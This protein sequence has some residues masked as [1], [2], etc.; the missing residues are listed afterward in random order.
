MSEIG[1]PDGIYYEVIA[2]REESR[3]DASR[4]GFN[5]LSLPNIGIYQIETRGYKEYRNGE[6]VRSWQD[7]VENFVRCMDV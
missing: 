5:D 7:D 4:C 6:L 2:T 3:S 1:Q